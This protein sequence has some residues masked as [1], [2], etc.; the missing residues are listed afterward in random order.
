MEEREIDL[1]DLTVDILS[2][3][4]GILVCMLA[5]ALLLGGFSYVRSYQR[6]GEIL[7]GAGLSGENVSSEEQLEVLEQELTDTE[8]AAVYTVINDEQKYA[9]YQQY[10]ESSVL[11]QMDPY[12]IYEVILLFKIQ[13]DDMGQSYMLKSVYEDLINGVGLCQWIEGQTGISASSAAELIS[14]KGSSSITV[15]NGLQEAE[16]G[17]DCLKVTI[18]HYDETECERLTQCVKDYMEQQYEYLSQELGAHEVVLL[19][20]SAGII[21]DTGVRDRQLSYANDKITLLTNCAKAKDAFTENQQAYYEL[22]KAGDEVLK[23]DEKSD[24][25]TEIAVAKPSVSVK[26]VVVGAVLF[27]FVYAGV[28]LVLYVL[29]GKLRTADELQRLYNIS[30][31]GLIVKDGEKKKFFID[32]WIDALRNWNKRQFTR[33]QSLELAAAAVKISAG[34]QELDTICLMGCDLKAGADVVCQELKQRLEQENLAV[35]I[36]DNVLYDASVMEELESAKGIVLVEKAGSTMYNEI[37][38]ELELASRQGIKV[39][40]G[41]VVE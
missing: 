41:I 2:H 27:A 36:L 12:N 31:M 17:N 10:V 35:K 13:I 32:R 38:R 14:A 16:I 9:S 23:E 24:E 37:S 5:G 11:M 15:I 33:E 3:W 26:Y 7:G 29:S 6:M 30:Q 4:R 22:L 34:K 20:E 28:F 19:S 1:I 18:A 21:M 39:L 25:G 8:K 40:G